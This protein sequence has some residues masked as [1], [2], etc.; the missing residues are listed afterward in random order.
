MVSN[1]G[2]SS[3]LENE[4][5]RYCKLFIFPEAYYSHIIIL[6]KLVLAI[7]E[8]SKQLYILILMAKLCKLFLYIPIHNISLTF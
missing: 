7:Q 3:S 2:S 1:S 4:F 6:L 5:L 8:M